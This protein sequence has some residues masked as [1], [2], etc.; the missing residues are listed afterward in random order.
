MAENVL[1]PD[2]CM[3]NDANC[4]TLNIQISLPG[5]NKEDIEFSFIEDGFFVI[6]RTDNGTYKGS[7][8]L[9]GPVQTDKAIAEY[10]N[11]MLTVNV[12]YRMKSEAI[13]KIKID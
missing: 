5:A 10:W 13:I 7:F 4:E 12:P 8:A 11:G 6:A 3:F 9:P 2:V 1:T